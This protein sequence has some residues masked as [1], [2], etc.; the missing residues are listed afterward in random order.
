[1]ETADGDCERNCEWKCDQGGV[2]PKRCAVS[3]RLTKTSG[4][5]EVTRDTHIGDLLIGVV[6][7]GWWNIIGKLQKLVHCSECAMVTWLSER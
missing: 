1:M 2:A 5:G 3:F 6:D 4:V 7:C